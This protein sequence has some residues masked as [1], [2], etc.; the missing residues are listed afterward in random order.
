MVADSPR[1]IGVLALQGDVDPHRAV[2]TRLGVQS[3]PVRAPADLDGLDGLILPGGESTA[4]GLLLVASGLDQAIRDHVARRGLALFGTCAGLILLART[5]KETP[6]QPHLA[7]LN[8]VVQRNAFGRQQQSCEALVEA[9]RLG[10]NPVRALF[11]RAPLITETGPE[12]DV[13]GRW[14]N[15]IVLVQQGPI[16]AAAFHSELTDDDRVHRYFLD[17]ALATRA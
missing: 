15:R 13:L 6:N 12:V 10:P 17:R 1:R 9:Q 5:I 7:L 11:I 16:L 3:S 8:V 2:L 4:I 14:N